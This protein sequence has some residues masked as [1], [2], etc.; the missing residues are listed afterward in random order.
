MSS[1]FPDFF[2]APPKKTQK[3]SKSLPQTT[4]KSKQSASKSK[5]TSLSKSKALK[6]DKVEYKGYYFKGI[7]K[8]SSLNKKYDAFF[9][10]IKSGKIKTV[11][12]GSPKV[13]DYT[14]T[15]DKNYRDFHN[16]TNKPND[17]DLTSSKSLEHYLLWNKS[18]IELSLKDY[19]RLLKQ[20]NKET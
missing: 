8:S 9:Q 11:S 15:N 17:Q 16:K 19:K 18:N 13:T 7:K 6:K 10:N 2:G 4:S 12:F 5:S 3:K 1:F 20:K 14:V